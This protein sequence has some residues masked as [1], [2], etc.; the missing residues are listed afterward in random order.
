MLYIKFRITTQE[1]F[2][3]FQKVYD[4]MCAV[5]E[6]NY[7]EKEDDLEIDW[8]TAT[9]EQINEFMDEDRLIINEYNAVFPEYS[10]VFLTNYFTNDSSK[11][12][13]VN[14]DKASLMNYLKY[15]F[16]VNL[17]ALENLINNE[18]IVKF[19]TGNYPFGGLERF[20]M[21]LKTFDLIPVE[22]FDG[23]NIFEFEWLS[24]FEY[25]PTI[26]EEKTKKYLK[27]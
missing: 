8:A 16:E 6:S 25:N 1:K 15:G 22:C 12:I 11:S 24:D 9:E 14:E 20:L 19:S 17:D 26:L 27:K 23:F 18:A 2:R 3:D 21:T 10:N 13:L 7:K 5:R 4:Y